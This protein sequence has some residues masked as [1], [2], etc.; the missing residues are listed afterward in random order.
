M[1][2]LAIPV[3]V[4]GS[5]YILSEQEKKRE[6]FQKNI[7]EEVQEEEFISGNNKENR[8]KFIVNTVKNNPNSFNKREREGFSNYETRKLDDFSQQNANLVNSYNNSN[9]HTDKF[10]MGNTGQNKNML[11]GEGETLINNKIKLMN[12]E[13]MDLNTFKHNNMQ[14]YFGAKIRGATVDLNTTEAILDNKQGFGSQQ[15][16]KSEQAPM[17][18]PDEHTK[19]QYGMQNNSEF[20]QSRMNESMKMSNVTLWEQQ[21]VGPGLNLGYGSQNEKGF[22][23][24]GVEGMGGYNNGM[25]SREYFMPKNVDELRVTNNQKQTFDLNGHQG[26]AI[27]AIKVQGPNDKIGKVEKHLPEKYHEV[28]PTRWFTTTGLEQAPAIRPRQVIP[29]ENRIDTTSEYY[30]TGGQS[31]HTYVKPEIEESKHQD[32]GQLPFSNATLEGK[33]SAQPGD[34]GNYEVLPNNRTT[35]RDEVAFGGV[36]GMAKAVVA[37]LLDILNPTRKENVIGNLRQSGNVNG[38]TPTGHMFNAHDKTKVTNREM[39]T[40]K[41]GMNHLNLQPQGH[42]SNAAHVAQHQNYNNQRTTTNYEHMGNAGSGSQGIR[43]YNAAYAQQNNVNKTYGSRPNQGNMN[44][45]NNFNNSEIKR[46][47]TMINNNRGNIIQ[48]GPS[49]VPSTEFMGEVNGIQTYDHTFNNSRMD[50]SLL[51]AFKSNPYTKSL[52]SYA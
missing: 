13:S 38:L 21:R 45:F 44:L 26:P 49:L 18:K 51:S 1:A 31:Q 47:E 48:G 8:E 11:S 3:V 9:Q 14:P 5:L 12:G 24:G 7:L 33:G 50:E 37:P 41:I 28:G 10:F 19:T 29:M 52:N 25:M 4:L 6:G 42:N 34:Y 39:T 16:S 35:D 27:S 20:F 17:F 15:F 46:D 30:G 22:N 23:T 43:T 32:L 40:G 36:Y 2:A